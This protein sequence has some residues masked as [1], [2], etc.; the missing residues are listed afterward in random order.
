MQTV[1]EVQQAILDHDLIGFNIH[2]NPAT[3]QWNVWSRKLGSDGWLISGQHSF[4][5]LA[6][7]G[8]IEKI[9]PPDNDAVTRLV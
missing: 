2:Y 1:A 6:L 8:M 7:D 9:D 5:A 3:G 4:L